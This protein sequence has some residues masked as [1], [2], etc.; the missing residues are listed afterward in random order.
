MAAV[1]AAFVV[2]LFDHA[3]TVGAVVARALEV[4]WPVFVVDDGST[5]EG[6]AGIPADPRVV[7]LRHPVNQGKGAALL[8]GLTAAA[9]VADYAVAVDADGQLDPGEAPRLIAA[10][11]APERPLVVGAREGMR[12][13]TVPFG[14]RFGRGFSNFWVAASGGP[15]VTDSQSGFRAYP[16]QETL[17]LGVRARRFQFEVEVLVLARWAGIPVVE[18]PVSVRYPPA[19]A[20]V[21]HFRRG[22]DSLRNAAVFSRLLALRVAGR[23]RGRVPGSPRAPALPGRVLPP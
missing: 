23:A 19:G 8:S 13:D 20:R 7:V 10:V 2:P 14:S 3:A 5:D 21:S 1:R 11:R 4:D 9:A 22:R 16:I 15:R 12:G 6:T 18:V 17:A